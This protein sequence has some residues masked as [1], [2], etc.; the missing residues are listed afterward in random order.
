LPEYTAEKLAENFPNRVDQMLLSGPY[1]P[2][3]LAR[4]YRDA[5]KDL[6][7]QRD[8]LRAALARITHIGPLGVDTYPECYR[9]MRAIAEEALSGEPASAHETSERCHF[10]AFGRFACELPKGHAG[11]HTCR[12]PEDPPPQPSAAQSSV[13]E[14]VFQDMLIYGLGFTMHAPAGR[15]RVPPDAVTIDLDK[16]HASESPLK[17]ER[18][19][20]PL[21]DRLAILGYAPGNYSIECIDCHEFKIADKRALR[22][23][24]CAMKRDAQNG[25]D[26]TNQ[27]EK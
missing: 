17:A 9:R 26:V 7:G 4:A 25:D 11:D 10:R 18:E 22:C 3:Y 16:L 19:A 27:L 2:A 14:Q 8:R 6:E 12:L 1:T 21:P 20:A 5:A 24:E 23:Y 13:D 15:R